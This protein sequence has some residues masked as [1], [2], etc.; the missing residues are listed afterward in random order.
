METLSY[1]TSRSSC[2]RNLQL[3]VKT[4][5]RNHS[6]I[7]TEFSRPIIDIVFFLNESHDLMLRAKTPVFNSA[8]VKSHDMKRDKYVDFWKMST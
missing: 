7:F 1:H 5:K 8:S 4:I 3:N 6:W 2:G